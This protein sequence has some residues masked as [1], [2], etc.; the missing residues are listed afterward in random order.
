MSNE[1]AANDPELMRLWG[2]INNEWD[3]IERLLYRAFDAMLS[4]EPEF[5]T[6]AVFYSQ[7]AHAARRAMVESLAKYA[8]L[9]RPKTAL[10]LK[11]AI[12]RVNTRDRVLG[13]CRQPIFTSLSSIVEGLPASFLKPDAHLSVSILR[14]D[15]TAAPPRAPRAWPPAPD[16]PAIRHR[17]I[18][19]SAKG[20]ANGRG[21]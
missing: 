1:M 4:E 15:R 8:L 21:G 3:K 2:E 16:R 14:P 12:K 19:R 17:E 20:Q 5:A 6:Q 7:K 13:R 10:K 18:R 9:D 11:N